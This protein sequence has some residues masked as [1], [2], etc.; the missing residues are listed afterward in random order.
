MKFNNAQRIALLAASII[1]VTFGSLRGGSI[2]TPPTEGEGRKN[3]SRVCLDGCSL[4]DINPV[5]ASGFTYQN[6]CLASCQGDNEYKPGSCKD[7][8]SIKT[9]FTREDDK[10]RK[11]GR[12]GSSRASIERMERFVDDGYKLVG[13]VA[14]FDVPDPSYM[15]RVELQASERARQDMKSDSSG[16]EKSARDET[17]L[18]NVTIRI[19]SDGDL[20]ISRDRPTSREFSSLH[21][22][23]TDNDLD[24]TPSH[25]MRMPMAPRHADYSRAVLGGDTRFQVNSNDYSWTWWRVGQVMYDGW[26]GCTGTIVGKNKVLTNSHCVYDFAAKTLMVPSH[27]SPGRNPS[28]TWGKWGVDYVSFDYMYFASQSLDHDYAIMTMKA[29]NAYFPSTHIGDYMGYI[30]ITSTTCY[31]LDS[32]Y[33]KK[34]VVGYPADKPTGTMWN[35]GMCDDWMYTCNSLAVYHQC[36]TYPGNS[37]SGVLMFLTDGTARVV[38]IHAYSLGSWNGGPAFNPSVVA[39][40]STW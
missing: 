1:D 21:N 32:T 3:L 39:K 28:E 7:S 16:G 26:G 20:Y 13:T 24:D 18:P 34:R 29:D 4:D 22:E 33:I 17:S 37:G 9:D 38:G 14:I 6:P 35:S 15:E 30:P 27:F 23:N 2:V 36:D 25:D 10:A 12:S 5:C 19:T 11:G 40:I 8:N 31:N